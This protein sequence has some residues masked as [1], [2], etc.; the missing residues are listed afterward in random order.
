MCKC[1]THGIEAT[2]D[3]RSQRAIGAD[4]GREMR[5]PDHR[6]FWV[7]SN[8]IYQSL[9]G[10][11]TAPQVPTFPN[12]HRLRHLSYIIHRSFR[13]N[14]RRVEHFIIQ[15]LEDSV[16]QIPVGSGSAVMVSKAQHREKV[17]KWDV[18]A[19][20]CKS[21]NL[22]NPRSGNLCERVTTNFWMFCCARDRPRMRSLRDVFE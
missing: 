14:W 7:S 6:R 18:S 2:T 5:Y 10:R 22:L 20:L 4:G 21:K 13:V 1:Y 12:C 17:F 3:R 9:N 16:L 11:S 8:Q 19:G 15:H